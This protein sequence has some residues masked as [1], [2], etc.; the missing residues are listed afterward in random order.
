VVPNFF[1]ASIRCRSTPSLEGLLAF[2]NP[3]DY[4]S[5]I[6]G[7]GIERDRALKGGVEMDLPKCQKCNN[8]LLIP[9]SDYGQDGAAVIF[10]AWACTNPDC[11]FSLRVD[12]G[13]VTYG[14]KIEP[15][16]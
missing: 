4:Y 13:E 16:H 15:K 3:L 9:L 11:G 6:S 10:K 7:I 5:F 8:G 2:P 12:K 1:A 14:R